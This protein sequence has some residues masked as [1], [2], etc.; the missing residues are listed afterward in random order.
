VTQAA[1]GTVIAGRLRAW[2]EGKPQGPVVLE[3]FPSARCNLNCV[4]CRRAD[5]YPEFLK[6]SSEV[7]DTR[8]RRLIEEGVELGVREVSFKGG[9]EPL[10]RRNLIEFS[11]PLFAANGIRGLLITNGTLVDEKLA[12]LLADSGWSEAAISLDAPDAAGHDRIRQKP[13]TFEAATRAARLLAGARAKAGRGPSIKFHAVLTLLNAA[14]MADMLRL[15][16]A[17]GA[18]AFELDSLDLS[19]PSAGELKLSDGDS[20]AFAA[21]LEEAIALAASLKVSNN[22][23]SFRKREYADRGA[24]RAAGG[25]ACLY[26]WF[27][28]SVREDGSLMPCCVSGTRGKPRIHDLS[29]RE[30]WFGPAMEEV[31]ETFRRG[32]RPA[33]C[34][35]CSPLQFQ[36]N[37]DLAGLL[38]PGKEK[39]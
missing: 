1:I 21:G 6:N 12:A 27:Q 23:A 7:P 4:F 19:E 29:L 25:P 16:A 35:N 31:R 17:C 13:G 32:A 18:D 20:L 14:R 36:F 33:F 26:P 11:A 5:H 15:A 39:P 38:P 8:Y 37:A 22:L 2:G 3:L 9:G 30:A 10:L 34:A 24:A 28:L